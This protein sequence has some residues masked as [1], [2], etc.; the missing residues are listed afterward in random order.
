LANPTYT[1]QQTDFVAHFVG[2]DSDLTVAF[3]RTFSTNVSKS[4]LRKK[5]QR[6]GISKT[7]EQFRIAWMSL[8]GHSPE[9]IEASLLSDPP[10]DI[11]E[12]QKQLS[13]A[14]RIEG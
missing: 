8:V 9:E 3:N 7:A 4:A 13:A 14:R 11:Y 6:M 12:E 2:S 10:V 5:R 1:A